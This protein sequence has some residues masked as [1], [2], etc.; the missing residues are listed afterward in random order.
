MTSGLEWSSSRSFLFIGL[1]GM[2]NLL[3]VICCSYYTV[4]FGVARSLGVLSQVSWQMVWNNSA[5]GKMRSWHCKFPDLWVTFTTIPFHFCLRET[6]KFTNNLLITTSYVVHIWAFMKPWKVCLWLQWHQQ[7]HYWSES[8]TLY[9]RSVV[10]CVAVTLFV[11]SWF[12][13]VHWAFRLRDPRVWLLSTLKITANPK[14][15]PRAEDQDFWRSQM[16]QK[17]LL[18]LP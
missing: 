7:V 14:P 4:L 13:T 10:N 8:P 9:F 5:T 16:P 1:L 12:G 18:G 11:C 15:Q 2:S 17:A 6:A 3:G